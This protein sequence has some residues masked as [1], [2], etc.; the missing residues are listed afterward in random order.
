M[1]QY[2]VSNLK[3][4]VTS[5]LDFKDQPDMNIHK[6]NPDLNVANFLYK[7]DIPRREVFYIRPHQK[8]L[9]ED[10][11]KLTGSYIHFLIFSE[12]WRH[13]QALKK[14]NTH[15]KIHMESWEGG[16]ARWTLV[17][18]GY[19]AF[20]LNLIPSGIESSRA[21]MGCNR[22][23]GMLRLQRVWFCLS[24]EFHASNVCY[25]LLPIGFKLG[26]GMRIRFWEDIWNN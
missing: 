8:H 5:K 16:Y 6:V 9:K 12:G 26:N 3:L 22:M 20:L 7:N 14:T 4:K 18:N 15:P 2:F 25:F 13:L 17:G 23:V 24:M 10:T 1:I 11:Y 21:S 19:G